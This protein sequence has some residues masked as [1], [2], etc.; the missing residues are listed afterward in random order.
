MVSPATSEGGRTGDPI[1]D[2]TVVPLELLRDIVHGGEER[3]GL[4]HVLPRLQR[5]HRKDLVREEHWTSGD[6]ARHPHPREL[7]R[8]RRRP[9]NLDEHGR[10][11]RVF[12]SRRVLSSDIHENR[13]VKHAVREVRSSLAAIDDPEAADLLMELDAAIAQADYLDGVG[14]LRGLPGV[15]TATLAGH[16]LYRTA[17]QAWLALRR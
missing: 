7:I 9:G 16:P 4:V 1:E 5:E 11:K 14:D 10:L 2:A 3:P 8:S 17:Y 6:L 13:V 12:D 15:P